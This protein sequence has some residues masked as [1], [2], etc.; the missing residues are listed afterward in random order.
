MLITK[1][2]LAF[3]EDAKSVFESNPKQET[4]WDEDKDLIALRYGAD[5]DS[6][7]IHELGGVVGFFAQMMDK[8]PALVM[9][10]NYEALQWFGD[11]MEKQLQNND[12]KGCWEGCTSEYLVQRI[13]MCI[14][15]LKVLQDGQKTLEPREYT[16]RCA[17]IANFAMMLADNKR[18]PW[19]KPL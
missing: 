8:S 5:R 19:D 4:H 2:H 3:L 7:K 15:R 1:R 10:F 13:E 14:S 17:N 18:D 9:P 12:V 16:R 6:I 11:E